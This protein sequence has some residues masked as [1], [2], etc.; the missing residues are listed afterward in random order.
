LLTAFAHSRRV[1]EASLSGMAVRAFQARQQLVADGRVDGTVP[2]GTIEDE[3]GMCTQS[4]VAADLGQVQA[5]G[6]GIGARQDEPGTDH[7]VR[8]YG[9]EQTGPGI[10][11]VAQTTRPGTAAG[12]DPSE[13]ALLTDL[14]LIFT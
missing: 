13:R 10:A 4:D 9:P 7:P 1:I 14:S 11:A 6:L 8:A 12:P 3:D 2:A 5:H